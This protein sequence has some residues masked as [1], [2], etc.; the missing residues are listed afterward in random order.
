[1]YQFVPAEAQHITG[2]IHLEK[3]QLDELMQKFKKFPDFIRDMEGK[4]MTHVS[5][6]NFFKLLL[7]ERSPPKLQISILRP[8]NTQRV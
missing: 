3:Q 8:R 7:Q 2:D 4:D 6:T 5:T 1:M